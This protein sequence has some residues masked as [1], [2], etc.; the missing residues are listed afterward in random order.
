MQPPRHSDPENSIV[1]LKVTHDELNSGEVG[2]A[3]RNAFIQ[4]VLVNIA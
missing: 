1:V 4:E 3:D 2:L